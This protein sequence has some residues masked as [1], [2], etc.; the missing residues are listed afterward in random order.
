MYGIPSNINYPPMAPPPPPELSEPQTDTNT[1]STAKYPSQQRQGGESDGSYASRSEQAYNTAFG[2]PTGGGISPYPTSGNT[3]YNPNAIMFPTATANPNY[4]TNTSANANANTN[5]GS[6][7]HHMNNNTEN[8]NNWNPIPVPFPGSADYPYPMTSSYPT[9]AAAATY[10]SQPHPQQQ[11]S[12]G[13]PQPSPY[14]Q[15]PYP[16]PTHHPDPQ[17]F[18]LS[19]S[20]RRMQ[21]AMH[22]M[23]GAMEANDLSTTLD[24]ANAMLG[25]LGDPKHYHHHAH[26]HAQ[27]YPHQQHS[28]EQT[29]KAVMSPKHYYELHMMALDELP[30]L[31][32]YFLSISSSTYP[33]GCCSIPR[34]AKFTMKEIYQMVQY[35]PRAVPRLYLM[36]CAG[37]AL[38]R[39][40]EENVRQVLRDLKE[41][42]KCVQCPIRGLFLR[43]YLLQAFKDKLPD[44]KEEVVVVMGEHKVEG[45]GLED[46]KDD[47]GQDHESK[48]IQSE[49]RGQHTATMTH[50]MDDLLVGG[51]GQQQDGSPSFVDSKPTENANRW[52]SELGVDLR[53][54]TDTTSSASGFLDE[55]IQEDVPAPMPSMPPPA[56]P[57]E[58]APQGDGLEVLSKRDNVQSNGERGTVRD[59][60]EFVLSNFIEM[61]KL[62][63]RIQHM[64]GDSKSKEIRRQRERERNELRMMV[65]TNLVR[66]SELEGV[67]SAIYGT[68][69]LP[70]I[71][72]QIVACHDPLA[73]AYLMD[74]IIQVFPDE[75]HIQ[76]L[77]VIL[78]VCPK[79][80]DK[81][82]I[83]TILQS[84]MNRLAN[85]YADE[86][87]LND[88]EDTEGVKMSVMMD[89]FSMFEE[90]IKSVLD[91]RGVKLTAREA[92]RLESALMEF[93]LKCYPHKLDY[94][95]RCLEGCLRALRG[96]GNHGIITASG[97]HVTTPPTPI[98][99]DDRAIDELE[100][101]LSLPLEELA[102]GVLELHHY[103]QLLSLLPWENQRKLAITLLK[104]LSTSG[105]KISSLNKLNELFSIITPLLKD[106]PAAVGGVTVNSVD[107]NL[108]SKVFRVI[109]HDDT[110]VHF[111]MLS[112]AYKKVLE[113]GGRPEDMMSIVHAALTLLNRVRDIEFPELFLSQEDETRSDN[114]VEK[115][116][117]EE[118]IVNKTAEPMTQEEVL[119]MGNQNCD[120]QQNE[121]EDNQNR[122]VQLNDKEDDLSYEDEKEED[123]L[124][125]GEIGT[126]RVQKGQEPLER[127]Y[128]IDALAQRLH[129]TAK[130]EDDEGQS[131]QQLPDKKPTFAVSQLYPS[132]STAIVLEGDLFS[133]L[134]P[135]DDTAQADVQ[136]SP[137]IAPFTK[138]V[139]CRK[140]FVFIQSI[141]A[142]LKI[143]NPDTCLILS[144]QA[145][146]AA[147][148]C[149]RFAECR[150][151]TG[152]AVFSPI[153]YT[154][155]TEAFSSY[156]QGLRDS[157]TQVNS[158]SNM[159][160]SLLSC[161]GFNATDYEALSTKVTQFAARL[162]KKVDQCRMVMWCSYLFY[163]YDGGY[164]NPQRALECLQ[165]SLKIAD[166]CV[167]SSP[168][169]LQLFIDILETYLYHFERLNPIISDKFISGLVALIN[170]H[171]GNIGGNPMVSDV[172]SHFSLIVKHIG[173]KSS[174]PHFRP[175]VCNVPI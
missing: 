37:S 60:Y 22:I 124:S 116:D 73:Q 157:M 133:S 32:E 144:T 120:V 50:L 19:Q 99:L 169:N 46:G 103:S 57:S 121:K 1:T 118:E 79:L 102:L 91:S 14:P 126:E 140:I 161:K 135:V 108:F 44:E 110:D 159:I 153:A 137:S 58:N 151:G 146:V 85:Y 2:G 155:F 112:A 11:Q 98:P 48:S 86:L 55:L 24:R 35:S 53:R 150:C 172:K 28:M 89:S 162:V 175:I 115:L 16:Q 18:L 13:P 130:V 31:E 59:S 114:V 134:P 26:A 119:T 65:G 160:G 10:P 41:G 87:L 56:I 39:S 83:R 6:S 52:M 27:Q 125:Y 94:M 7:N 174:D 34:G 36:I 43:H 25:E 3:A 38:I 63:V 113:C 21:E 156:E 70:K 42:V 166:I 9:P 171:I 77:E 109:F 129:A 173:D 29:P 69:I 49:E 84:I 54:P 147:D 170:E 145:A 149:C 40:G 96:E 97:T 111:E 138:Q 117:E 51:G 78:S 136:P 88:E 158:V 67:T 164:Q 47:G 123:D 141:V 61:N 152:S 163:D 168:V 30:N 106:N 62:W 165:R 72:D 92:I 167:S 100:K 143:Q 12:Y 20:V 5:I 80:R 68:V 23:R 15:Q 45:E 66:L 75:F 4:S 71:L 74:C 148:I 90:C 131:G 107:P 142:S 139:S 82:N 104:V 132:R 122:E 105:E 95:D 17:D 76:T 81:V 127:D 128:H 154:F 8:T 64:P 93:T 33:E 101:L